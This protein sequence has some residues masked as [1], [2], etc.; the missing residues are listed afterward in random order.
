MTALYYSRGLGAEFLAWV[1]GHGVTELA[2]LFF[3]GAAGL[4]L[5][6]ALMFPGQYTR[7][8]SLALHGRKVVPMV[9]GAILMFFVAA[10]F[11]GYFRQLVHVVAIRW[12]V[13]GGTLF[14]WVWYFA[15]VGRKHTSDA[16]SNLTS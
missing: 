7:S 3:C 12:L 9:I 13:A 11:E 2:A 4:V 5:G 14:F 15:W 10:V 1:M 16:G 8:T 6:N